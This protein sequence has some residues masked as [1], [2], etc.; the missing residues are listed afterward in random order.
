MRRLAATLAGL[1]L[2]IVPSAF[3]MSSAGTAANSAAPSMVP[4][5]QTIQNSAP[6]Q[7]RNGHHCRHM[8]G[9][10][11]PTSGGAPDV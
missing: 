10:Q 4:A 8:G 2:V 9:Q 5:Y 7:M 1:A 11:K 3:A 6:S